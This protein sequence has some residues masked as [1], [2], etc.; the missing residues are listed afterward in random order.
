MAAPR[1]VVRAFVDTKPRH[2]IVLDVRPDGRLI[3]VPFHGSPPRVGKYEIVQPQSQAGR[4]LGLEKVTHLGNKVTPIRAQDADP[5]RY[6]CPPELFV[7]LLIATG[8]PPPKG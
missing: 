5:T 1:D 2:C 7:R 6:T 3:V 8:F 4:A